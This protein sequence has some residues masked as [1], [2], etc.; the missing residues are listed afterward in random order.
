MFSEEEKKFSDKKFLNPQ[1]QLEHEN[2][3]L[4][5]LKVLYNPLSDFPK[6]RE[7]SNVRH[8]NLN[9]E[10]EAEPIVLG[11]NAEE[12]VTN[13]EVINRINQREARQETDRQAII[14]RENERWEKERA[15]KVKKT[16]EVENKFDQE[17]QKFERF[18]T[19]IENNETEK[20][21]EF[22]EK[23]RTREKE[24]EENLF[25]KE[26][27]TKNQEYKYGKLYKEGVV[28]NDFLIDR[29]NR[30]D[31]KYIGNKMR[32]HEDV[33]NAENDRK[34]VEESE[35]AVA[36]AMSGEDVDKLR[37]A[38]AVP[39]IADEIKSQEN[40]IITMSV[41]EER[42]MRELKKALE[43]KADENVT[44][45]KEAKKEIDKDRAIKD[46]EMAGVRKREKERIEEIKNKKARQ[47]DLKNIYLGK[48]KLGEPVMKRYVE[49]NN[50]LDLMR[51]VLPRIKNAKDEKER[52]EYVKRFNEIAGY[53]TGIAKNWE[54]FS[55]S[56]FT[57]NKEKIKKLDLWDLLRQIK[58]E[59]KTESREELIGRFNE[60]AGYD[61]GIANSWQDFSMAD[62]RWGK[63]ELDN[64]KE[65]IRRHREVFSG[66]E[67][68]PKVE[69][70]QVKELI[71][72]AESLDDL[73]SI[74][75]SNNLSLSGSQGVYSKESLI[76]V[77]NNIRSGEW[78]A[79]KATR[80]EGFR[81]KLEELLKKEPPLRLYNKSQ[82][83]ELTPI[84][85]YVESIN[86]DNEYGKLSLDRRAILEKIISGDVSKTKY[87]EEVGLP[88][89]KILIGYLSQEGLNLPKV[90]N[91]SL[92][93]LK[94]FA[95]TY[96]LSQGKMIV[97]TN[98]ETVNGKKEFNE[99]TLKVI[100]SL[101]QNK[102]FWSDNVKRQI[103]KYEEDT[104]MFKKKNKDSSDKEETFSGR[105]VA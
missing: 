86:I 29:I 9:I 69:V 68:L 41:E 50:R 30:Q 22:K 7:L 18:R 96:K 5:N 88:E 80:S 93:A 90:K 25:E 43:K 97:L 24:L 66:N 57:E 3:E 46:E 14:A 60:L 98:L 23:V 65:E 103:D 59:E 39:N 64:I 70:S 61:T 51:A 10:K 54:T 84:E 20:R 100:S 105:L 27:E 73:I 37:E 76:S 52:E 33:V 26:E 99:E 21:K 32:A 42:L 4:D 35:E 47:K 17:R 16:E 40:S 55:F 89:A 79:D 83:E 12:E 75:E 78:S 91:I 81:D 71:D 67:S 101:P 62:L 1:N 48:V 56:V 8:E 72:K 104:I 36:G 28:P 53:D 2:A 34:K 19:E 58:K 74:V 85:K 6:P 77:I 82:E 102:I 92:D 94:T 63:N 49:V 13:E 87:L 95:E 15:E 38:I 31:K 44:W 11:L 45:T